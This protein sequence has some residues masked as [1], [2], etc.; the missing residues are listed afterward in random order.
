MNI[1][2]ILKSLKKNCEAKKR[3]IVC[4][5]VKIVARNMDMFLKFGTNLE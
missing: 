5:K 1:G 2:A 3:F 4:E